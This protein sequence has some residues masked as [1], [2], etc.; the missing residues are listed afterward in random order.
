MDKRGPAK[1]NDPNFQR[2]GSG[3]GLART[4]G[5]RTL[6]EQEIDKRVMEQ[7]AQME[8]EGLVRHNEDGTVSVSGTAAQLDAYGLDPESVAR[9]GGRTQMEFNIEAYL[10]DNA[11]DVVLCHAKDGG[12]PMLFHK[13][14]LA[15][16]RASGEDWR[17]FTRE[18]LADWRAEM[19]ETASVN[20]VVGYE[21]DEAKAL[22][23]YEALVSE[24]AILDGRLDEIRKQKAN[25]GGLILSN[26]QR[27]GRA[28]WTFNEII[29]QLGLG[30][31]RGKALLQDMVDHGHVT[32]YRRSDGRHA[33][34]LNDMNVDFY[35]RY[36]NIGSGLLG[37]TPLDEYE[38]D[39]V[40]VADIDAELRAEIKKHLYNAYGKDLSD[41][42]ANEMFESWVAAMI[43]QRA[44]AEKFGQ[45][46]ETEEHDPFEVGAE[47]GYSQEMI[48]KYLRWYSDTDAFGE[49]N[50]PSENG[51]EEHHYTS[52]YW[53]DVPEAYQPPSFD[54]AK[55]IALGRLPDP[56]ATNKQWFADLNTTRI[57]QAS[58]LKNAIRWEIS[59]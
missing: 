48:A 16:A 55:E 41:Q 27:T 53:M 37:E 42:V 9:H 49:E 17:E 59:S 1:G 43:N 18:E 35:R 25:I 51:L 33:Y 52:I 44:L 10:N 50:W 58:A 19:G 47:E 8:A 57:D 28:G 32:Q 40:G 6:S 7:I 13:D 5:L 56:R 24:A 11:N 2:A 31:A 14:I 22:E 29:D 4:D 38:V 26:N 45:M 3:R 20:L 30:E 34:V 46:L 23:R 21:K 15:Q 39:G 54:M 12:K 36:M